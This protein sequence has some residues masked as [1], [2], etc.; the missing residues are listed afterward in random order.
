MGYFPDSGLGPW[1][2]YTPAWT[3][4]TNPAIGNGTLLGRYKVVGKTVH[5]RIYMSAGSTTTFGSGDWSF[6]LPSG[7]TMKFET[8]E[9]RVT[10]GECVAL[11]AGTTWRTGVV[12][13]SSGG[14]LDIRSKDIAVAWQS[15]TP[16]TW[17][18]G[19]SLSLTGT[20]EIE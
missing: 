5:L 16:H 17:T 3:A 20:F 15:S 12:S 4:S 6:G 9:G 2:D 10:V 13:Q 18:N 19:D 7:L 14:S 1:V 11:D 8:G